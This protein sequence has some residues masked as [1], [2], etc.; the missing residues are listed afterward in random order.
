MGDLGLL[1]TWLSVYFSA[2]WCWGT[3]SLHEAYANCLPF[4][5]LDQSLRRKV[6][7]HRQKFTPTWIVA[8]LKTFEVFNLTLSLLNPRVSPSGFPTV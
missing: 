8:F 4:L 7:Q 5:G 3:P 2:A 6:W 1:C